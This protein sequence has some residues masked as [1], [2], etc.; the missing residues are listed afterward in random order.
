M[1]FLPPGSLAPFALRDDL[2]EIPVSWCFSTAAQSVFDPDWLVFLLRCPPCQPK[3]I[4]SWSQFWTGSAAMRT[5]S[6]V[7]VSWHRSSLSLLQET[8]FG[9]GCG[10][11]SGRT[12]IHALRA[13]GDYFMACIEKR[14]T[15]QCG[16]ACSMTLRCALTAMCASISTDLCSQ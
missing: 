5:K 7:G 3:A 10:P 2:D 4:T 13:Q 9:W 14:L 12:N 6:P 11:Y 16:C 15:H 1:T 8:R